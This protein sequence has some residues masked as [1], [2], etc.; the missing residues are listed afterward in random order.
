[1]FRK[2]SLA[3]SRKGH[4]ALVQNRTG[5][6]FRTRTKFTESI[7]Q[8]LNITWYGHLQFHLHIMIIH[9]SLCKVETATRLLKCFSSSLPQCE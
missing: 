7:L 1:M 3:F 6:S 9:S 8:P 4:V 5:V 2:H